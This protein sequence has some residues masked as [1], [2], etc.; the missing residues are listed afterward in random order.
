MNFATLAFSLLFIGAWSVQAYVL[1]YNGLANPE[2]WNLPAPDPSISTNIVN[3]NSHAIRF[4]LGSD[5]YSTTNAAAEL[6]CVRAAFGQ[7]Q[8]VPGTI[9]K[10]EDAGLVNPPLDINPSDGTNIVYWAK[11]NFVNGGKDNISGVL[12]LTYRSVNTS[13]N[14]ILEADIVFNGATKQWFTDF[15]DTFNTNIFVESVALHEIGHLLGLD[16]SPVGSATLFFRGTSGVN[17]QDGLKDD[18]I[19][20]VRFLYGTTLTNFGAVKGQVTK[21]GNPVLG[22]AVFMQNSTSNVV[23]G[24]LTESDGSYVMQVLSPGDCQISVAPL[25]PAGATA[26]LCRGQ[27]ISSDFTGADTV[28]LPTTNVPVTVTANNTNTLNIEVTNASPAFRITTIRRPTTNPSSYSWASA[29]VSMR[30]GQS[31]YYIGVASTN[32]PTNN[33][34]LTVTGDG[35]TL[36]VLIF[37]ANPFGNGLNFISVPISVASNATPGLRTFV[38]QQGT[39]MAYASGFL[40]IQPVVLDYNFDGLDDAFQRTYFPLF[41]APAAA[42]SADPDSDGMN[43]YEEYIAGTNPTNAASILK[44]LAPSNSAGGTTVSWQSVNGKRYQVS[45]RTNVAAGSWQDIGLPV[46]AGGSTGQYVDATATNGV[47]FYRVQVL[48]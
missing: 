38:V 27:D 21:D 28:F 25:D 11:T 44:M 10:F 14:E 9:V 18:D 3:R 30:V 17:V 36:G 37:D 40:E 26:Y 47:R 31:N 13:D 23:C 34:T 5:G 43:N 1:F 6:N 39:N 46:T 33:A 29:P 24:T 20:G 19:S 12:G 48:P 42:P 15:F 2:R 7:W 32:L 8:A 35:L 4:F 45:N 22:A 41:T 16:H